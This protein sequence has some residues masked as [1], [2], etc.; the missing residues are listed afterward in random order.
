LEHSERT[1]GSIE[2]SIITLDGE[3]TTAIFNG[4]ASSAEI[5]STTTTAAIVTLKPEY[6]EVVEKTVEFGRSI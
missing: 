4:S 5:A 3:K 2:A 1:E 6:I